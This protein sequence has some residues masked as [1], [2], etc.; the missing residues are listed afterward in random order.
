MTENTAQPATAAGT[1]DFKQV[2]L[3]ELEL[4][5]QG[6]TCASCSSRVER[7]LAKLPGVTEASVNLATERAS[8]R[9]DPGATGPETIV[10][11]IAEAGYEPV[12]EEHEIGVGGMTC[13]ACSARVER[14]LAKLPGVVEAGVNL[15]TERATMRYL[16]AMLTPARIAQAIGDAGYEP[17]PLADGGAATADADQAHQSRQRAMRRDLWL[18]AGLTLPVLVL[19]MGETMLPGFAEAL[20]ALAPM[21]LW[22]ALQALLT[23]AVLL[24]P[25]RRFFRPGLIAF[26]HLSPDMNSLVMTGTSAAWAYSLAVVLA[27]GLFPPE[28]RNV[29][30]DSA[31]VIITVILLGK[32][33]EELA[34]G[35]TSSAIKKLIGLQAKTARALRDGAEVEVPVEQVHVGELLVVRPGERI[36]VDGEVREGSSHVDE[37]M[38]TGEPLPVAKHAGDSVV[39]ATINQNGRLRIAATQVGRDTVLAQIVRLVER[40]QGSKLPI[41]GLADRVVRVFTPLVLLIATITFV[42]WLNLG[43][44]PAITLALVSAVSVLVVACPCAMGLATPAAIMVGSGRAA[45]LGVLYR[46]G[47]ALET[48]SHVDTV[49]FDKTGT[50]TEGRPRLTDLEAVDGDTVGALALAAAL[51]THSEHPLGAAIVAAAK[52]Q[53]LE[54]AD[55]DDFQA[56]PGYGVRASLNGQR[57][58]LGA[59]RL[60]RREEISTG[61]LAGQAERLAAAGRTP[62]YLAVDGEARALLAVADPLKAQA[63]ALIQALRQRGLRVAMITGDAQRTAEAIARQAGIEEIKAQVLPDGKAAA[64]QELQ[65][66]GRRVAFVGDGINDAPALAQAEVGITVGGGTDIAIEAADVTLTRNDLGGVVTALDVA[67]RTL[68]T[69]RGNLFWAFFYN[70][71]LIPLA[72]GVFYPAFGLHLHPMIAGV[73]MGFSSLFVVTNSLRLRRLRP[74]ALDGR[75]ESSTNMTLKEP[76]PTAS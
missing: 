68:R 14:A 38:L 34:K 16:P 25:G 4:G 22:N 1:R 21:T 41:Q 2:Q 62:I 8:L 12:V 9:F 5:V 66:A 76:A 45:E 47:E 33:L 72:A 59:E 30:F 56:L 35:R 28:A 60:M 61:A 11:T 52:E 54:P 49:V 32:Y 3:K 31:A 36:P 43:P 50:L 13:A 39:G 44:P 29:Y 64:V 7:A 65:R 17:R 6:M 26:R 48:L 24:G 75:A 40:A 69:I 10:E 19:S 37:S 67:R 27:P 15:A 51:E 55:V 70:I 46:K 71:L 42:V 57:L 73:A 74:V 20:T 63:P 23:T 58:L 53:G 18:A